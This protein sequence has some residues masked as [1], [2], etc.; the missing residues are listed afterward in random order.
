VLGVGDHPRA[1]PEDQLRVDL[2][3]GVIVF[4][5]VLVDGDVDVAFLLGVDE[6]DVP[7]LDEVVELQFAGL[8]GV[9]LLVAD[10]GVAVLDDQQRAARA[11][12]VGVDDD[13]ARALVDRDV[14]HVADLAAASRLADLLCELF[15][16]GMRADQ[17]TVDVYFGFSLLLLAHVSLPPPF[18]RRPRCRG[19]PRRPSTPAR[20]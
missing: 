13:L 10:E 19:C 5:V 7:H 17:A 4:E 2:H 9:D 3:V 18:A 6:L 1:D 11:A 16:V 15:G 20:A 8:D 12:G 14:D